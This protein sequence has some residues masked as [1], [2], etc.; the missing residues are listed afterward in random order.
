MSIRLV[1]QG[2]SNRP[3]DFRLGLEPTLIMAQ[4]CQA[5]N[6]FTLRGGGTLT[7]PPQKAHVKPLLLLHNLGPLIMPMPRLLQ[8]D[9]HLE[10]PSEELE[11][12]QLHAPPPPDAFAPP[13]APTKAHTRHTW[14]D[15]R[16]SS[17]KLEI[18]ADATTPGPV[19]EKSIR[20]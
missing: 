19:R 2:C 6:Y 15:Q 14:A 18:P 8:R 3:L 7:S 10:V 4:G 16:G 12:E 13:Q 5:R 1:R 20:I 9:K 17:G 11:L